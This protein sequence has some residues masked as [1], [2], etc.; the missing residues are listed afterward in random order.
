MGPRRTRTPRHRRFPEVTPPGRT[1][2]D[3]GRKCPTYSNGYPLKNPGIVPHPPY[4]SLA[5]C[6]QRMR[7][8]PPPYGEPQGVGYV[9]KLSTP[10]GAEYA[11]ANSFDDRLLLLR[12]QLLLMAAIS[13]CMPFA[14]GVG[15][16]RT[17]TCLLTTRRRTGITGLW[18]PS[19]HSDVAF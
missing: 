11:A 5:A 10:P 17:T 2:F 8:P 14:P 4:D 16:S 9:L 6:C 15:T 3:A 13:S 7:D 12:Q 18:P 1:S 19:V